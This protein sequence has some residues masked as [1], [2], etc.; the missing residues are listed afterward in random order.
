MLKLQSFFKF[1]RTLHRQEKKKTVFI[2]ALLF[3][4]TLPYQNCGK[5]DVNNQ[6][7][8]EQSSILATNNNP[9]PGGNNNPPPPSPPPPPGG[10]TNPAVEA[11]RIARCNTYLQKP[12]ITNA[13]ALNATVLSLRSGLGTFS[14]DQSSA[15]VAVNV[16]ASKGV[17]NSAGSTADNCLPSTTLQV[18]E[19][20]G[21]SSYPGTFTEGVATAGGGAIAP[22][23]QTTQAASVL[24]RSIN[25]G[26]SEVYGNMS[27]VSFRALIEDNNRNIRCASGSLYF[28]ATIRVTMTNAGNN[29]ATMNSDPVCGSFSS[30][31]TDSVFMKSGE[32]DFK[33][34][35]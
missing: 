20:T 6:P 16:D 18:V 9:S 32:S 25:N 15:D 23:N 13:S 5:F 29:P 8:I 31:V 11:A 7:I 22:A 33:A 19:E 30:G 4:V 21:N 17:A 24:A 14:G 12:V 35:F 34:S 10:G 28:R 26:G 27:S 1:K 2:L 3:L